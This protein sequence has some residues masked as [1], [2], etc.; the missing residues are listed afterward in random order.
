VLATIERSIAQDPLLASVEEIS[1]TII[2]PE[3][4]LHGTHSEDVVDF[5]RGPDHK[6]HRDVL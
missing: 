3:G 2:H 5:I 1:V 4:I 6:F